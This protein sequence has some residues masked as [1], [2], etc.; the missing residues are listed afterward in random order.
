MGSMCNENIGHQKIEV[1][2]SDYIYVND[3]N[4]IAVTELVMRQDTE[5]SIIA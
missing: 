1:I 5:I 4:V 2:L 3:R